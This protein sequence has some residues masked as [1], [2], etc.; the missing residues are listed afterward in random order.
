MNS[1]ASNYS[2]IKLEKSRLNKIVHLNR[3]IPPEAHSSMYN[4]HKFWSRKTWNVV[5]E[6]IKTYCPENGI[7]FD[8]FAGS[9]VTAIESLK[10]NRR[11]IVCDILPSATEIIRLTIKPIS[12]IKLKEAFKR[13]EDKVKDKI[14][15]LYNTECRKCGYVFPMNCAIWEKDECIEIRYQ[16][17]PICGDRREK[18]TQPFEYDI[19]KLKTIELSKI[20][21]WYP[22]QKLYHINGQPFKE[23]QKYKSLDEL[24]TKRNLQALAWL[25]NTIEEEP[26]KD[27]RDFL[28]IA[29]TSIVHLCTKMSPVRP[30]RPFSS[31]WT[32]HSYWFANEFM[33]QNVWEKFNSAINGPQG[34]IRAKEESNNYFADIRFG[35]NF[36][37]VINNK[38]DIFIYTGSSFNLMGEMYKYYGERGC[39]DYIFTDP[40][41]DESI[42]YGELAYLWI[43][44]LKKDK[45]YLE[46]IASNEVIHN[47]K[48]DKNFNSYRALL[49]RS[50]QDMYNLLKPEKYLTVTF[51]NP[52]L[53]VRSAT[54]YSGIVSGFELEKIHHQELARPSAKSL[55]QPFGSAQGDFYLRFY[56]PKFEF[57]ISE[58]EAI[59]EMRFEKIVVETTKRIIAERGEPT[60]Y[61]IIINAIDPELAKQGFFSE[62]N[63]GLGIKTVLQ[64]HLSN[65]FILVPTKIGEVEGKLWWFKNP[66][67]IPHLEKIP[68]TER[69]EQ[70][71]LRKL[72]QRGRV[73]F[74]EIWEAVSNEFP[75]SLTSDSVSIMDALKTYAKPIKGKGGYWLIKPDFK[76]DEIDRTHTTIIAILAEIGKAQDYKIWVGK[77]EQS[78]IIKNFK[79]IQGKLGQYVTYKSIARLKNIKNPEI[80]EDIDLIWIKDNHIVKIFEIEATTSI[81]SALSRGSN[82][83]SNI[84]KY[85]VLP[86][87]RELQLLRKMKSPMFS[88]RFINDNWKIIYFNALRENYYKN[89]GK[90]EIDEL[91]NIKIL[92]SALKNKNDKQLNLFNN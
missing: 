74:T 7:T 80:I 12:I 57:L 71:V 24:F 33:E 4:W 65:E 44:W 15:E 5:S 52:S 11:T 20:K 30:T 72:Q 79:N 60:P 55:L 89:K 16:L 53:K 17:C 14:L 63:T 13:I 22:R 18:N 50:F 47:E 67:I 49:S 77:I 54:I 19:K 48:Q 82:A 85:L 1:D 59:S 61:T 36:K 43:C 27:L 9:G 10:N 75:N 32:E 91:I 46:N 8:P 35:D 26:N 28:K 34:L 90:T 41:Y 42:Q 56:K 92:K 68:L 73:T 58:K 87:D 25:M 84:T 76:S 40:P 31:A 66:L 69:V 62:L 45:G 78:H 37:D 64:K 21:E 38:A 81:I 23:K 6:F 70:T 86:E 29:F 2:E 88:E 51:H 39:I 3:Q 83:D